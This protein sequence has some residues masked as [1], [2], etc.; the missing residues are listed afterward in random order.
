VC[1]QYQLIFDRRIYVQAYCFAT[2]K[3][4]L[5]STSQPHDITDEIDAM[6]VALLQGKLLICP[7]DKV[8]SQ[9][10]I[11]LKLYA[12]ISSSPS[13]LYL[14]GKLLDMLVMIDGERNIRTCIEHLMTSLKI[15]LNTRNGSYFVQ[16]CKG[17]QSVLDKTC[18]EY[19]HLDKF[20]WV[21]YE[22]QRHFYNIKRIL[23]EQLSTLLQDI[24]F[25]N[26]NLLTEYYVYERLYP[27]TCILRQAIM[28]LINEEIV[29]DKTLKDNNQSELCAEIGVTLWTLQILGNHSVYVQ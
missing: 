29:W 16:A 18:E 10:D 9:S 13:L 12:E 28:E 14:P 22:R 21:S 15:I 11:N 20:M 2:K 25:K 19:F 27:L 17:L 24:S 26:L 3:T 1:L 7:K 5:I 8:H 23:I 4:S 6:H